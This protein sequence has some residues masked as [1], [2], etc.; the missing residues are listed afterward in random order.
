VTMFSFDLSCMPA[1]GGLLLVE[2]LMMAT[3]KSHDEKQKIRQ[4][5]LDASDRDVPDIKTVLTKYALENSH[6]VRTT[7]TDRSACDN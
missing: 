1:E 7:I 4:F 5:L 2:S 3:N 6:D